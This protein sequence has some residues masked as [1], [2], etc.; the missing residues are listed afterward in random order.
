MTTSAW[1]RK[2]TRGL[3]L[4]DR[5]LNER[6]REVL[7]QLSARPTA[8]IPAACGGHAEMTAAYRLFDNEK[9]DFASILKPHRDATRE[10]IGTQP[11]V[12]L[13]QDTTELDLTRPEQQMMGAGML[14]GSDRRGAFLHL[15]HAFTP[16]GTPLG[17]VGAHVWSRED[18]GESDQSERRAQRVVAPIEDKESYRWVATQKMA[19]EEARACPSTQV[20]TVADSESDIY[21]VFVESQNAPRNW[22]WI[23]RAAQDRA[24]KRT[25]EKDGANLAVSQCMAS[26]P[27]RFR[28]TVPVRA[29]TAL[30]AIE[31]RRRR[32]TRE[33]RE[34]ELSVRSG[35][36]T[37]RP[38]WRRTGRLPEV[39]VHVVMAREITPPEGEEPVEWVLF[40]SLPIETEDEVRRVLDYYRTRWMIEIFFRVLKSGCRVEERRFE[41]LQ[42]WEVCLAVYLIVAWRTLYVTRV[43]RSCPDQSCAMLFT[44]SE[45]KAVWK[46]VRRQA[47]PDLAPRLDEM[48][49]MVAQLGGYVNRKRPDPPGVQTIWLG[50]QRMHDMAAC[51]DAFGPEAKAK[52]DAG[53]GDV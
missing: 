28:I 8:G 31:T 32:Q 52:M 39:T 20:V 41:R 17:T 3:D 38:P 18:P 48:V 24:L 16:D 35:S 2:E 14:D 33:S 4:K 19:I 22:D 9:A 25:G 5:R 36:V 45:W 13:A 29:R 44:P 34:A 23:V 43:S 21:E 50:L 49:R 27:D 51:W 12:V 10:R 46:V 7:S 47:L 26:Q 40:T 30:H 11:V 15:L 53:S 37:L 42:R 6:L 1:V